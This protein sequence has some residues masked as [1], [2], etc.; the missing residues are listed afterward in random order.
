V[1]AGL[2]IVFDL[3]KNEIA[4]TQAGGKYTFIKEK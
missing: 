1:A 3:T 4:L 2:V